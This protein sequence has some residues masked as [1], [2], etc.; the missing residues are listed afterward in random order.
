MKT[1]KTI[2]LAVTLAV[3]GLTSCSKSDVKPEVKVESKSFNVKLDL[4]SLN[5]SY[6][7]SSGTV[8]YYQY[9]KATDSYQSIGTEEFAAGGLVNESPAIKF[10]NHKKDRKDIRV[11]GYSFNIK[12]SFVDQFGKRHTGGYFKFI[13]NGETL[14]Y[15]H[16]I[17][18]KVKIGEM[19]T[20]DELY[21]LG[22]MRGR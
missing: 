19:V 7:Y 2:I 21:Q 3:V 5:G 12:T 22:E 8:T 20:F 17:D 14:D 13:V 10:Y 11:D 6:S 4:K 15:G 9:D 18:T 16:P 1:I